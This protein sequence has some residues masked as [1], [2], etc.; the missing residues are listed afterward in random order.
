MA[1]DRAVATTTCAEVTRAIGHPNAVAVVAY[2]FRAVA[3]T[4]GAAV[5]RAVAGAV[6]VAAARIVPAAHARPVAATPEV[7]A[8]P[9]TNLW[10]G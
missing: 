8:T 9:W 5:H 6:L 3:E 10:R 7:A 4:A 1:V 2:N